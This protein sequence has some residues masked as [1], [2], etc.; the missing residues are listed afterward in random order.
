MVLSKI[1]KYSLVYKIIEYPL[2]ESEIYYNKN[3]NKLL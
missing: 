1:C 3:M 2:L